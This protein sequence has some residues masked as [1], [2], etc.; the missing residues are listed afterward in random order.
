[1]NK[2]ID[3]KPQRTVQKLI[4]DQRDWKVNGA[5]YDQVLQGQHEADMGPT[6]MIE[7]EQ[8]ELVPNPAIEFVRASPLLVET[9]EISCMYGRSRP[10]PYLPALVTRVAMDLKPILEHYD[11]SFGEK[12]IGLLRTSIQGKP[13]GVAAQ[14]RDLSTAITSTGQLLPQV[15]VYARGYGMG[16]NQHAYNDPAVQIRLAGFSER[17]EIPP[18]CEE[19]GSPG[20]IWVAEKDPRKLSGDD[21]VAAG[22]IVQVSSNSLHDAAKAVSLT[23]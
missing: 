2:E 22:Q 21:S 14:Q 8:N 3:Q 16:N 6:Q 4:K 18:G 20:Q 15:F 10:Y 12:I 23:E 1:M 19:S 5:E 7:N 11:Q 13:T 9:S 17:W